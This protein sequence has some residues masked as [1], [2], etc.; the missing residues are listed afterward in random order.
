MSKEKNPA[1]K[2]RIKRVRSKIREQTRSPRLTVFRSGKHTYAQIID[3]REG[4]T[5]VAA[6]EKE[7]PETLAKGK[8]LER[9]AAVGEILAKKA[10]KKD[11]LKV[12]FD[13]GRYKFHGR[14]KAL[15]E[16][17]RKGGLVF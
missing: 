6:T 17:A 5:L 2:K 15:A 13:R 10:V 7:I 14:I 9:A 1:L 12:T 11:I 8:K 4:K 16:A 3:D